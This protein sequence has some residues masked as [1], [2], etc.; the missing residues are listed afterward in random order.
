MPPIAL[1]ALLSA[2]VVGSV[3]LIVGWR[4]RRVN[5]HPV[6]RQCRFDLEG[7]YPQVVT[8]PECGAGLKREKGV[9]IGSRRRMWPCV[10]LGGAMVILP[11]APLALVL[12]AAI[13]GSNLNSHKPLGLLLWEARRA[14]PQSAQAI[15]TEIQDR[16]LTTKLDAAQTSRVV[17]AGLALQADHSRPWLETWGDMIEWANVSKRASAEQ[18]KRYRSQAAPATIAARAQVRAG[19]PLPIEVKLGESRVARTTEFMVTFHGTQCRIAGEIAKGANPPTNPTMAAARAMM[20]GSPMMGY[21]YVAGSGSRMRGF[22]GFDSPSAVWAYEVPNTLAP[23]MYD[24]ELEIEMS[25]VDTNTFGFNPFGPKKDDPDAVRSTHRARFEVVAAGVDTVEVI[26]PTQEMT[27]RIARQLR[28]NMHVTQM[29]TPTG[30]GAIFGLGRRTSQVMVTVHYDSLPAPIAAHA[31]VR[32]TGGDVRLNSLVTGRSVSEFGM[33]YSPY[34]AESV[35]LYAQN[36][37]KIADK[38]VALV[39]RPDPSLAQWSVDITRV[40]GGEIIIEN[41]SISDDFYAGFGGQVTEDEEPEEEA[42][43]EP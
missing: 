12:F 43:E 38:R 31:S 29:S 21:G 14:S 40:Y 20:G 3:L 6:C 10:V 23:G 16:L 9:R 11:V 24:V 8:C 18:M 32:H 19:D 33:G 28:G 39:L 5:R 25:G 35:M 2:L 13:T 7:L 42:E 4:G 36:V 17:D 15:A 22:G 1:F 26:E 34:G 30:L 27:E 41:L 37:P